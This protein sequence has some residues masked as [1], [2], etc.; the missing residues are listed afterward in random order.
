M[1]DPNYTHLMLIA[2]RSGSMQ[3]VHT[4]VNGAIKKMMEEQAAL[5]GKILVDVIVFDSTIDVVHESVDPTAVSGDVIEPRGSTALN[6]AIGMGITRLG[7]KLSIMAEDAR[8]SNVVVVIATDGMEN[9]SREYST[10]QVKALVTEQTEKWGW[11]FIYLAANVDAFGT[12]GGYGFNAATT[13]SMAGSGAGMSNGYWSA[14][15]SVTRT[16]SGLSA[17]FTDEER[18]AAA[19]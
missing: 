1:T 5:E 13:M 3:G 9:A 12:G 8:P 2:D 17:D 11:T 15:A 14:S 18:E 6:D 4:D 10:D 16:R 19:D 7:R